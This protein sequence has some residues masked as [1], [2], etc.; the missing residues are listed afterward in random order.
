M[1]NYTLY[2]EGL[3][4]SAFIAALFIAIMMLGAVLI[5]V[6]E[7]QAQLNAISNS[8]STGAFVIEGMPNIALFLAMPLFAP[9]LTL[10]LFSFL[11]KR[12]SSDFYHAIPHRRE[13]VFGSFGTA[14]LTWVIGGIWL[15]VGVSLAIFSLAPAGVA[16][17][18]FSSVLLTTLGIT[19]GCLLVIA[20]TLTAM[21]VTGTTFAGI[22]T[23]LLIL[24][25]PRTLLYGFTFTII[26][27]TRF[28]ISPE[29]FGILGDNAY[30]F[31]FSFLYNAIQFNPNAIQFTFLPGIVYTGVLALIYF[32]IALA[33]FKRR[34]SETA[35][36]PAQSGIL[37]T[38]IR[39]A[40]AFVVCIPAM[41]VITTS[42]QR[43]ADSTI[44]LIAIYA[45]AVI[46]YFAYE[47]IS[48]KKLSNMKKALPGLGILVLLNIAFIA[49][50]VFSGNAILN[51]TIPPAQVAAVRVQTEH[52]HTAAW[53]PHGHWR[54]YEDIRARQ[55]SIQ[56]EALTALLLDT[57]GNHVA[58]IR[59]GDDAFHWGDMQW[60]TV[61]FEMQTGRTIRRNVLFPWAAAAELTEMLA[62]HPA[63]SEAFLALPENPAFI[64]TET[65]SEEATREIYALLREEVRG[66]DLADW[67]N[68]AH[69]RMGGRATFT[70]IDGVSVPTSF[71]HYG[72]LS[73]QGFLGAETYS[74]WYPITSLT[75]RTAARFVQHTNAAT[76]RDIERVLEYMQD[77]NRMEHWFQIQ[78]LGGSDPVFYNFDYHSADER[79]MLIPLLLAA[80]RA[81]GSAPLDP[82][83]AQ[84]SIHFSAW[85]EEFEE[86]LHGTFFFHTNDETLR[87][88]LG[89]RIDFHPMEPAGALT[90]DE[91]DQTDPP[92]E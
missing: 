81:Q 19:V 16:I 65:L 15:S 3:R 25:L 88:A 69:H 70:V 60:I 32:G 5:P 26:E 57:L 24:F 71:I 75:P 48:T 13:V 42:R 22:V 27:G 90:A 52:P 31:A 83:Q 80:I 38:V 41:M 67:K 58:S 53:G 7:I 64:W 85:L 66:L 43:F 8:W 37:Q 18:N 21:S 36:T 17:I 4:R 51:R 74:S 23:A 34:K 9:I 89:E 39:I 50:A 61:V 62:A 72:E 84:F 54:S 45:I 2:K 86:H 87:G 12:S 55:V 10:Y 79:E 56:D 73:V 78:S 20:A 35:H 28:I 59:T 40:V 92:V 44:L 77:T 46:A 82:D 1:F 6:A 49:G 14:L 63:Y 47:L 68:V 33:L 76:L 11:N 91:P 30:N 29:A